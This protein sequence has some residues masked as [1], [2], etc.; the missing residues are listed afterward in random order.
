MTPEL[1]AVL[2][3]FR[4]DLR[5]E[6]RASAA[7]TRAHVDAVAG[8]TRAYVDAS[9]AQTRAYVDASAAQTRRELGALIEDLRGSIQVVAEGVVGLNQKFDAFISDHDR[10][11]RRVDL[12]EDR[13]AVLEQRVR[14]PRRKR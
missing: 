1:T 2:D 14:P 12:V 6:I 4:D 8:E 5:Q 10:L 9:A 13:V 11:R 3:R 7:Q